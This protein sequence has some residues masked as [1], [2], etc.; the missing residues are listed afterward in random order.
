MNRI[1]DFGF[2]LGIFGCFALFGTVDFDEDVRAR[3]RRSG[4]LRGRRAPDGRLP[5]A[6]SSGRAARARRSRSTSGCRTPWPARRPSRR[7]STPRR[8]SP[9]ASTWSPAA[10]CFFR[11]SHEWAMKTLGESATV[12]GLLTHDASF[13]VAVVGG[14][15]AFF[16]ATMGLA[17]TDIKKVLAYSTVSQLGYMFL[18]CGVARVRRGHVPRLHARLVQGLPLPRLR[19]G[20][21]RALGR[22]GH[23]EDGRA[24]EADPA[25]VRHDVHRDPRDR[26]R[27]GP[28]G[29]LLEGRDPR[30]DVRARATRS[31]G[32]RGAHGRDDGLLHVPAHQDDVLRR[33]SAGRRS[34]SSTSTSRPR[35]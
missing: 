27:P 32:A 16:A 3:R 24:A 26:G 8:W 12:W 5:R 25:H 28:R 22:A 21:P 29:L 34:S 17:Q 30:R 18:G 7:S 14:A 19:L 33:R 10:T 13:V 20:H 4:P 23:D 35:R 1:G 31:S 11:I 6:S 9:P 15:T 2:V